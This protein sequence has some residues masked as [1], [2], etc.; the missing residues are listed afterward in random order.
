MLFLRIGGALPVIMVGIFP[1][2]YRLK[3][4]GA[5]CAW[6]R[7]SLDSIYYLIDLSA[8]IRVGTTR[9]QVML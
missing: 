8:F 2:V 1:A 4:S 3:G 7:K 9:E 6:A 5:S